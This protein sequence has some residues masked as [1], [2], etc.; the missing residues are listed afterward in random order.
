[1]SRS[2]GPADAHAAVDIDFQGQLDG[3]VLAPSFSWHRRLPPPS[4]F[5]PNANAHG[6]IKAP[7]RPSAGANTKTER[8]DGLT[9]IA[10][11]VCV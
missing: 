2:I 6:L 3:V 11:Q 10:S 5:P 4:P 1:M 9:L 7:A 8:I